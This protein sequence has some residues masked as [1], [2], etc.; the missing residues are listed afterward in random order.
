MVPSESLDPVPSN[1]ALRFDTVE[2]NAA[3][4][5]TF[6]VS[7]STTIAFSIP[8]QQ[9]LSNLTFNSGSSAYTF[10]F[11][12]AGALILNSGIINNSTAV[13]TFLPIV[14]E[15]LFL[16]EHWGSAAY[17]GGPLVAGL[18]LALVGCVLITASPAVGRL[19]AA[20]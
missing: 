12:G 6:G 9:A 11:S 14:L 5:A 3:V 15:P 18:A 7:S 20:H 8:S 4:G 1:V 10:N 17:D 2:E 19:V 13:Q 16:R